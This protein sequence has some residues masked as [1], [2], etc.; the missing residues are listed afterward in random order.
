MLKVVIL[1]L[2][3]ISSA[4]AHNGFHEHSTQTG[5][6]Q[7]IFSERSNFPMS[8]NWK[9]DGVPRNHIY[10]TV[11]DG[12]T[13][14]VTDA[15]LDALRDY[16]VPATFFVIGNRAVRHTSLLRTIAA[17]GHI[18]A[19][20]TYNHKTDHSEKNGFLDSLINTNNVLAPYAYNS[21]VKLFRSPGGIWNNWRKDLANRDP[22]L[23]NMVGPIFWNAGGGDAG[24]INDA[25]WKCWSRKVSVKSCANGYMAAIQKNYDRGT[26]TIVLFHDLNMKSA[27]LIREVLRRLHRSSINW[28][29]RLLDEIPA[30]Q[31]LHG[32]SVTYRP[33][34]PTKKPKKTFSFF[35]FF[36]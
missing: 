13:A 18:V 31:E 34:R 19:N 12:P 14:K 28:Q 32:S 21:P 4:F 8:K 6:K 26:A 25:D 16:G 30:V 17:E 22:Q 35:N 2:I 15:V 33:L 20:H 27:Q 23:S 11:D 5:L 7:K 10:F 36:R 1:S 29:Y 3:V 9:I 24:K